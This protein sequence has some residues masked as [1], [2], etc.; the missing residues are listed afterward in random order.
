MTHGEPR[1]MASISKGKTAPLFSALALS[2]AVLA[3]SPVS[4]ASAAKPVTVTREVSDFDTVR[5]SGSFE[6]TVVVGSTEGLTITGLGDLDERV[7]S[8][9]KGDEL[10]IRLAS[11]KKG[12]GTIVIAVNTK[13]LERFIVEGAG[14]FQISGIESD[15][16]EVKLPGAASIDLEGKCGELTIIIAGA[17]HVDAEH[18]ICKI[19]HVKISGT[20][21]VSIHTSEEIDARVSG[22]GKIEVFGEPNEIDQ[23]VSGLGKIKLH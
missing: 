15:E 14:K 1:T 23:H 22:I 11:H 17:A 10:R 19:G 4:S 20:G 9:V 21:T 18:L 12:R 16:F 13:E 5:L 3:S 2:V 7:I 8:E 6:G